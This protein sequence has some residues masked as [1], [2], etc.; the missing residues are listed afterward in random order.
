LKMNKTN[1][2]RAHNEQF[3]EELMRTNG[4][5]T[6]ASMKKFTVLFLLFALLGTLLFSCDSADDT[7]SGTS[8]QTTTNN[9]IQAVDIEQNEVLIE[10]A[11]NAWTVGYMDYPD[12]IVSK[13][14]I[15]FFITKY[16][17]DKQN[18]ELR[19]P[20]SSVIGKTTNT[21]KYAVYNT[22]GELLRTETV[23]FPYSDVTF[24]YRLTDYGYLAVCFFK[25]KTSVIKYFSDTKKTE[26]VL[27][28]INFLLPESYDSTYD[29]IG[30]FAEGFDGNYYF[31]INRIEFQRMV[32][33]D[34]T[35]GG[36]YRQFQ[37]LFVISPNS[38]ILFHY[39]WEEMNNSVCV[40]MIIPTEDKVYFTDYS[41][42]IF[43]ID[44]ESDK[45]DMGNY[46]ELPETYR[47]AD[48][49]APLTTGRARY[50]R[51]IGHRLVGEGA[52]DIYYVIASGIY[53]LNYIDTESPYEPEM[54]VDFEASGLSRDN[55][56]IYAKPDQTF[57]IAG[58]KNIFSGSSTDWI[59]DFPPAIL[60]YDEV[61]ASKERKTITIAN[62]NG[63]G[64]DIGNAVA[65]FNMTSSEYRITS[66]DYSVYKTDENPN[67]A[68]DQLLKEFGAGKYPDLLLIPNGLDYNNLVRKG[69]MAN[70]YDLGFDGDLMVQ[71][72]REMSEFAGGL[73]KLP[74]TFTYTALLS[75]DG[76]KS[77]SLA[78]LPQLYKTYGNSLFP[79]LERDN[80]IRY[81][82][83][84]GALGK[85]IDYESA[86]CDFNN[87]EFV[88]F[89][90]FLRDYNNE[91]PLGTTIGRMNMA[92]LDN[93]QLTK[94]GDAEY[95][96]AS[97]GYYNASL[98]EYHFLFDGDYTF[99]GLPTT[100]GSGVVINTQYEFGITK[101]SA[102]PEAALEFLMLLF[103]SIEAENY[104]WQY[105]HLSANE[106]IFT[107][108]LDDHLN[109]GK[110][111]SYYSMSQ[112]KFTTLE[113][114]TNTTSEN[115]AKTRE[116][117]NNIVIDVTQA[118]IDA[119]TEAILNA[120][121]HPADDVGVT[122]IISDELTPFLAGQDTAENVAH[123]INSR[124]GIYLA[125]R[126]S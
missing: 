71:S 13:S 32:L 66:V 107:S 96:V 60:Y 29:L 69:F 122:D 38:E 8:A 112:N 89:L 81:L 12:D 1:S 36:V 54:I 51:P 108:R 52:H 104:L 117:A 23:P 48:M 9:L 39:K 114:R 92:G 4:S 43:S 65:Y 18:E 90:N 126:Y 74:M 73:Y 59:D 22:K 42:Q 87:A 2:E 64:N 98:P 58:V 68:I 17:Y 3:Q 44:F 11:P 27:E 19:I 106:R 63:L 75:R 41:R 70:L 124:V 34:G 78:D 91:M 94:G 40:D 67:G 15:N 85:F 10:T 115:F 47:V 35:K 80:L 49:N 102:H 21:R 99:C 24:E 86:K 101:G 118:E 31:I 82:W 120:D 79:Q 61:K 123:R 50:H 88:A 62:I 33:Q 110:H 103:D 72:V 28:N 93:Q 55:T 37:N 5:R 113:D 100:D 56:I 121:V 26:V 6:A 125:E 30:N 116:D 45:F 25:D 84:A 105:I 46:P 111:I 95:F 20:Y 53:G 77:L 16:H 119:F 14:N 57:L 76:T 83:S 7:V 109:G 97:S